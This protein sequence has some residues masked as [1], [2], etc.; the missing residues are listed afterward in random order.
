MNTFFEA[1]A[2]PRSGLSSTVV[3]EAVSAALELLEAGPG[4]AYELDADG[5]LWVH[6]SRATGL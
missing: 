4:A 5:V 1:E 6:A 2:L 3:K